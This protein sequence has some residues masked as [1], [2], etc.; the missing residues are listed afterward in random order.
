MRDALRKEFAGIATSH[1]FEDSI[2][3]ALQRYM[4]MRGK[5]PTVRYKVDDFV[6][7]QIRLATGDADAIRVESREWRAVEIIHQ[8]SHIIH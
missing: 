2:T 4:K 1:D 8:T 3:A 6:T 7:Q 5:M